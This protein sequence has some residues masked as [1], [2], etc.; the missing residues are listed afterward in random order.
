MREMLA[1]TAALK[2]RGLNDV[3]LMTDGRFSGASH[4][5]VIGHVSP[6][7]AVGGPISLVRDGDVITIDTDA[8]R[9]DVAA[10]LEARRKDW[11]SRAKPAPRGA[12]EKYARLVSSASQGAITIGALPSSTAAAAPV[13]NP[14]TV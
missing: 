12:L 5:F 8:R 4:G 6:E 7:A 13:A 10:D 3:C 14:Q 9:I 11:V 1:V 2:G